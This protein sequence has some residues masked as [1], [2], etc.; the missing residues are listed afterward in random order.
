M[1]VM[2]ALIEFA[3]FC[4]IAVAAIYI[5]TLVISLIPKKKNGNNNIRFNTIIRQLK[6]I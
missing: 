5:I 1:L 6:K 4:L 2:T 3:L